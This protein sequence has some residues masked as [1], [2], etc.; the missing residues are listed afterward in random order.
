MKAAP[1][2]VLSISYQLRTEPNGPVMDEA[3]KD[4]PFDFLVGYGNV[5]DLFEKNLEGKIAGNQFSFVLTPEQGYG[6]IDPQAVVKLPKDAF[7]MDG[8]DASHMIEI[9]NIIPLQD[10]NGNPFQGRITVIEEAEVTI[11]MNHPFAGKTLYFSG[12]VLNVR[13]AHE[14]EK[15]HGHVHAGG[16]HSHH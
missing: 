11:D 9:G 3:T 2:T 13:E 8:Q 7:Q 4:S 5:L 10:Q 12:E 15:Q 1:G 16:D 6:E 14:S